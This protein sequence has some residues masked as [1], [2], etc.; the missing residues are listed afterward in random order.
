MFLSHMKLS[1]EQIAKLPPRLQAAYKK[2]QQSVVAAP[3]PMTNNVEVEQPSV[4]VI[5]SASSQF[6]NND[7]SDQLP[8][9]LQTLYKH[10]L[11]L[12]RGID[13]TRY[14]RE[15]TVGEP[16]Q[17]QKQAAV[18]VQKSNGPTLTYKPTRREMLKAAQEKK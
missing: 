7:L 1:D 17:N 6:S 10:R 14:N 15:L 8:P 12:L 16:V 4:P 5:K 13:W 18:V 11:E 2:S 3:K 9:H